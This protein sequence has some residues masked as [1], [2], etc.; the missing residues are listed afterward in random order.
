M[1]WTLVWCGSVW[2]RFGVDQLLPRHVVAATLTGDIHELGR[3]RRVLRRTVPVLAIALPVLVLVLV[4]DA[5]AATVALGAPLCLLAASAWAV[6]VVLG[7]LLRGFGHIGRSAVVQGVVPASLL[8]VAAGLARAGGRD[9]LL[10]LGTSTVALW[11]AVGAGALIA[12]A[13]WAAGPCA[14]R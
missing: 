1:L 9:V 7:A 6:L 13:R 5:D 4:P 14:R 8:L 3:L 2:L 12:R 10:V 11:A